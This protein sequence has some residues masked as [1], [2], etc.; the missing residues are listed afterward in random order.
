MIT[1]KQNYRFL[2]IINKYLN[3]WSERPKTFIFSSSLIILLMTLTLVG[4]V[5]FWMSSLGYAFGGQQSNQS[6][7]ETADSGLQT[8]KRMVGDNQ[9]WSKSIQ[10]EYNRLFLDQPINIPIMSY[11]DNF[12]KQDS[13]TNQVLTQQLKRTVQ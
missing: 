7:S 4:G 8:M 1:P 10:K 5:L 2:I 3:Y 11:N 9:I 12:F 13:S 6:Q